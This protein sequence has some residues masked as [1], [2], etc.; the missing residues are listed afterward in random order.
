MEQGDLVYSFDVFDTA[1]TRIWANPEDVLWEVG[2]HLKRQGLMAGSVASW[3]TLRQAAEQHPADGREPAWVTLDVIYDTLQ[4][5]CG[6]TDEQRARAQAI[7]LLLEETA[8]RGV[9][10]V[11]ALIATARAQTSGVVFLSD[12]YLPSA[13]IQRWL[14]R[15]GVWGDADRLYVSGEWGAR[16]STGELY[17]AFLREQRL[18]AAHVVHVGD[19]A[20]GDVEQP[21]RLGIRARHLTLTQLSRYEQQ[22]AHDAALPRRWRSLVAGAMRRTRL[23]QPGGSDRDQ[24]IRQ[25]AADVVGPLTVAF[26]SWCFDEAARDGVKRLYFMSREGQLL[27]RVAA[28]LADRWQL[29]IEC[30]YLQGSRYA[31]RW[32]TFTAL[33]FDQLHGLLTDIPAWSLAELA[34]RLQVQVS[35]LTA[36]LP[37]TVRLALQQQPLTNR[38]RRQ[39]LTQL[40]GSALE[41][42]VV[43]RAS[44]AREA[45]L[46]Y[47][48]QVGWGNG[49]RSGVVD[50]GSSG[51]MQLSLGRLLV[52]TGWP[53]ITPLRGYYLFLSALVPDLTSHR[54][55]AFLR[56]ARQAAMGDGVVVDAGEKS[57]LE[58]LWSANHGQVV[59][60]QAHAGVYEPS[61]APWRVSAEQQHF[62][63]LIHEGVIAFTTQVASVTTAVTWRPG[64]RALAQGLLQLFLH[65]QDQGEAALFDALLFSSRQLDEA[66]VRL[67]RFRGRDQRTPVPAAVARPWLN[68]GCGQRW[69]PAWRNLD[70]RPVH[71]RVRRWDVRRGLPYLTDSCGVVYHSHLL[72]HLTRSE[73]VLLTQ[74][75]YRVLRP[76][77]VLRV[78]VAHLEQA[79]LTYLSTLWGVRRGESEAS[80]RYS[81]A[82]NRLLGGFEGSSVSRVRQVLARWWPSLMRGT[83]RSWQWLYDAP[84]VGSLLSSTGFV[85]LTERTATASAVPDW[86]EFHLDISP[87]GDVFWPQSLFIEGR[88]PL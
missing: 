76:G 83:D 34:E 63:E 30:R 72:E 86:S 68:L 16:K 6:W 42:I 48:A 79:A 66:P 22:V 75:C 31:W 56:D 87:A 50:I 59:N 77:G 54:L 85:D 32:P 52:A 49:V 71:Q 40:P 61:Y 51:G 41:Q 82:L 74:E 5:N 4:Q 37:A 65:E 44:Q 20:L 19:S 35:E 70:V 69:H 10:E 26:V 67:Q 23:E 64:R 24:M 11:R 57:L 17:Q 62:I 2:R 53:E 21:R 25:L 15:E 1:L 43:A 28:L 38:L 12:M 78:G 46:G 9:P 8:V 33:S 14:R 36:A 88:K 81:L 39:I 7:E 84:S 13:V 3:V 27:Q 18:P 60:Y 47:L 45:A 29:G 55:E 80:E 73:A 58:L